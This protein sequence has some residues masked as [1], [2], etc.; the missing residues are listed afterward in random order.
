M[1]T[2]EFFHRNHMIYRDLKPN[3]VIIDENKMAVLIDFDRVIDCDMTTEFSQNF[4][5]YFIDPEINYKTTSYENDIYSLGLMIYYII[6]E[7]IPDRENP[8]Q[9]KNF[10]E[11]FDI[12][13]LYQQCVNKKAKERP[14]I[15]EILLEFYMI[16][17]SRIKPINL[18][19]IYKTYYRHLYNI[20]SME[21]VKRIRSEDPYFALGIFYMYEK[22]SKINTNWSEL[23]LYNNP[24]E[25]NEQNSQ[26]NFNKAIYYFTLSANR[27]NI[28]AQLILG[29]VLQE[30]QQSIKQA[31]H[32]LEIG[33][34]QNN[35]D[36]QLELSELY[37]NGNMVP[38]DVNKTLYYLNLAASQNNLRAQ[39]KLGVLYFNGVDVARD[40]N[41]AIYYISLAANQGHVDAQ[42]KQCLF[43]RK[44]CS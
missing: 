22:Y 17:H 18:F 39:Y 21:T 3:N 28:N 16:Y 12:E 1:V 37:F 7:E 20:Q 25:S 34:N 15:I 36:A 30:Q 29:S 44:I 32:Y 2:I 40:I 13:R 33:A 27:G 41:K 6:S 8:T 43:N 4:A 5:S 11:F 35:A 42:F 9:N 10:G 26:H 31:M 14:S 19:E 38:R 23:K 24:I